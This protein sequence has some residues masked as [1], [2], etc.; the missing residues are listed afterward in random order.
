MEHDVVGVLETL[1]RGCEAIVGLRA[2][3]PQGLA[4]GPFSFI[5]PALLIIG[6]VPEAIIDVDASTCS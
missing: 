2:N 1:D 4:S 3:M 5:K 6:C